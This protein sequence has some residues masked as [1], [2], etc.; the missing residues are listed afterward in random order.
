MKS[1]PYATK[2]ILFLFL[3][4]ALILSKNYSEDDKRIKIIDYINIFI[5]TAVVNQYHY[6]T[7]LL[8]FA[9]PVL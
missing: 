1:V 2:L 8:S 7:H 9:N 6:M 3:K 5:D 4:L